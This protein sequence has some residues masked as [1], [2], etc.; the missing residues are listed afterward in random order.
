MSRPINYKKRWLKIMEEL[1]KAYPNI[2]PCQHIEIAYAD[3]RSI[4]S[5]SEQE[6]LHALETYQLE[7]DLDI[8]NLATDDYVYRIQQDAEHMFDETDD[9]EDEE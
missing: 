5:I 4:G 1:F 8:Q 7:A 3:Y 6:Q 9:W 2:S